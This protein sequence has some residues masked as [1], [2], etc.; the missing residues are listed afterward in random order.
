MKL[1][2]AHGS[3]NFNGEGSVLPLGAFDSDEVI[4]YCNPKEYTFEGIGKQ[5]YSL[6][7][8]Y[9][10]HGADLAIREA[11]TTGYAV[12]AQ[13]G[14]TEGW[15][16]ST[17]SLKEACALML[18]SVQAYQAVK[19]AEQSE[20]NAKVL[21]IVNKLKALSPEDL[22]RTVYFYFKQDYA[23]RG[24]DR[25]FSGQ[26]KLN[27][28][29]NYVIDFLTDV[30]NTENEKVLEEYAN[31]M[32]WYELVVEKRNIVAVL[33]KKG[34]VMTTGEIGYHALSLQSIDQA[35]RMCKKAYVDESF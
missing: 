8:D 5:L 23:Y 21:R 6:A 30:Q 14:D 33:L 24:M 12:V 22:D 29:V 28:F 16:F 31:T 35:K 32:D 15:G 3:W 11:L 7:T 2:I 34:K 10:Y 13:T 9:H 18:E 19:T 20:D 17:S 25:T 4:A 27:Q 26:I 1:F